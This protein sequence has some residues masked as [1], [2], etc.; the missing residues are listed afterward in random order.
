MNRTDCHSP[1]NLDPAAYKFVRCFW[2][3]QPS[4]ESGTADRAEGIMEYIWETFGEEPEMTPDMPELKNEAMFS[5]YLYGNCDHCGAHFHYGAIFFHPASK[6]YIRVGWECATKRF[7][8]TD[9]QQYQME[10]I[11]AK[12]AVQRDAVKRTVTARAF[13]AANCPDL[14]PVM[15]PEAK[16]Q[17]HTIL[18]DMAGKLYQYGSLSEKQVEFARKLVREASEKAVRKAAEQAT[19]SPVVAGAGIVVEGKVLTVKEQENPY[20]RNGTI[21]KMLVMDNRGFKVWGTIPSALNANKGDV[22]RFTANV[23][24]SKDDPT[25]GFF[26]R[27][28]KSEMVTEAA[29]EPAQ[30]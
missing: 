26:S 1:L 10:R 22:V 19:L 2:Q 5:G 11:K 20:V 29:Q 14:V 7:S 18:A 12:A 3:Y 16:D 8:L 21:Y 23:E 4:E 28:R 27:P 9:K 15:D 25:F 24:A 13:L 6:Q 30:A 17:P